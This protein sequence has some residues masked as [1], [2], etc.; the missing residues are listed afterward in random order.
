MIH[1]ERWQRQLFS[2]QKKNALIIVSQRTAEPTRFG[3]FLTLHVF[4]IGFHLGDVD[5]WTLTQN[6][7]AS[8]NHANHF[9]INPGL[10]LFFAKFSN[11]SGRTQ[12]RA[13]LTLAVSVACSVCEALKKKCCWLV[14]RHQNQLAPTSFLIRPR[15]K[16]NNALFCAGAEGRG[17]NRPVLHQL[18]IFTQRNYNQ[19]NHFYCHDFYKL[20]SSS[21]YDS[22][23]MAGIFFSYRR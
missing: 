3:T 17:G 19:R 12:P 23:K 22:I 11:N 4:T 6:F 1:Q 5:P 14:V 2:T 13:N 7:A 15:E 9:E 18:I 10:Q 20:E 16:G 21:N 8:R